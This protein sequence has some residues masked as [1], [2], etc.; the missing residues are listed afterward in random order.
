[1]GLDKLKE[2]VKENAKLKHTIHRFI[3]H[4]IK[5][6]PNWWIRLFYFTYIKKGKKSVIYKS[7]RLDLPP[8]NKFALGDYSVIEDFSCINN[9]VGDVIIG[10]NSRIGLH[11]TIIGPTNIG[12]HVHIGQN[13]TVSGLNHNYSDPNLRIDEQGVSTELVIISDDVWIGANAMVVAGANIG[14]HCVVAAGSVVNSII[15]PYSVCAGVPAKVIK[16][17]DFDKK[18]WVRVKS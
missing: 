12:S 16:Q 11:N 7:V 10:N 3:M 9:A 14:N 5:T 6:R 17:Y 8:F 4:P 2:Y 18:E 1:M 13:T 15:P